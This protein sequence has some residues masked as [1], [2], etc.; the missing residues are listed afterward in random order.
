MGWYWLAAVPIFFLMVVVH[1]FGHFITAKWAGIRVEEFAIGFPPRIGG[2]QRGE[3]LYSINLLP[4]GGFVRMPGENGE[5]TDEHGNYDSGS[6]AAKSAGKRAIVLL[7]GVTMNLILAVIL[8]T[9]AEAAGQVQYTN[10]IGQIEANSP[11]QTAG[12]VQGDR[13]LSIDGHAT[14]YF[15]DI[16]TQTKNA[17]A[18]GTAQNPQAQTVPLVV[19]VRQ[20]ASG[21]TETLTIPARVNPANGQGAIGFASDS[22][23]P[24]IQRPPLW[25]T[26][27]LG[28]Q[29]IGTSASA[30]VNG[31][32]MIIRG[33]IPLNKAVQGPVG[34]VSTT[35]TFASV[36]PTAGW[37][38]ILFLAG[39][40]S[41]N[42]A[43]FNVL[44]I[45]AL[46][47]G[48]LLFVVI[49]VLRRGK[50][51]SPE[52]EGLV[53]LIGMGCLLFLVLLVTINDVTN[54]VGGH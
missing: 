15:S 38:P 26:P 31:I 27:L 40:L 17:I 28:V 1:E 12:L 41:L 9:A 30:T 18:A 32:H 16:V 11:A 4:I 54:I 24:I 14:P 6:F 39:Y 50:R 20:A 46:D 49:E 2:I 53:N 25:K 23:H 52:R 44:P 21:K 45:P 13:I 48:R 3:T 43:V 34:I 35:A 29:D 22:N 10:V 37:Y 33:A 8:F 19:V 47:G 51:I 7:G 5:T 36:I 42:L